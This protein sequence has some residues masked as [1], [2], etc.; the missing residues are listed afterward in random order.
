MFKRIITVIAAAMVVLSLAVMPA[1][2]AERQQY[3]GGWLMDDQ[4]DPSV[5]AE[6]FDDG[7]MYV[8][9]SDAPGT[10]YY[11]NY[12]VFE[13]TMYVYEGDEIISAFSMEK[14]DQL[15]D[16]DQRTWTRYY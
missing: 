9:F 16:I 8:V 3:L 5:K 15:R 11:Y 14:A 10:G 4:T 13:D 7:T 6:I 1:A 2:A 12:F